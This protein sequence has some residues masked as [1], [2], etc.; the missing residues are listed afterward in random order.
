MKLSQKQRDALRTLMYA[1]DLNS[2]WIPPRSL[3]AVDPRTLRSFRQRGVLAGDKLTPA[4][5]RRARAID[6]AFRARRRA[7][8]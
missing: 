5:H 8:A 6:K 4:A 2:G 3:Q 1:M 7:M